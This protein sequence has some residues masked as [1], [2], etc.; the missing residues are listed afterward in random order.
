MKRKRSIR[1]TK[2]KPETRGRKK[3]TGP[4]TLIGVRTHTAFLARLDAWRERQP[5]ATTRPQAMLRLAER[6][7]QAEEGDT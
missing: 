1:V 4:G 7:L 3:T 5:T 6:G 2:K